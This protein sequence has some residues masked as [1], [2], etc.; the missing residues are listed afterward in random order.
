M[1]SGTSGRSPRRRAAGLG[2]QHI[3]TAAFSVRLRTVLRVA[4]ETGPYEATAAH[5]E[6]PA[7][8]KAPHRKAA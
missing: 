4:D 5:D 7:A 6:E 8:L 2:V 1:T 3:D